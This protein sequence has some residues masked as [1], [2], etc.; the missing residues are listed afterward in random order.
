MC[1]VE[2]GL[3]VL[4]LICV[5]SAKDTRFT[6]KLEK[7]ADK[8]QKIYQNFDDVK[9]F[10]TGKSVDFCSQTQIQMSLNVLTTKLIELQRMHKEMLEREMKNRADRRK[11]KQMR[12]KLAMY[13]LDR[14]I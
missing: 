5:I 14:H 12:I 4:I 13:F 2:S 7:T 6:E 8:I 9:K 11:H 3:F 1:R 10:C